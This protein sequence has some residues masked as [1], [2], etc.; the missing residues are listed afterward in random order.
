MPTPIEHLQQRLGLRQTG[1][2][3]GA[4][5]GAILAYQGSAKGQYPMSATGH[6][7]PATLANLG[8]YAPGDIFTSRW[9]AY[10][11]GGS[12]PSTALRDI[13][14]SIDQVPRWVWATAAVSFGV[15]A[16]MAYRTDRKREAGRG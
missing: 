1:T 5:D 4:T 13:Q 12:K 14:T 3:D 8:Y 9:A 10:L 15:F 6:P 11:E 2:W 7:D 16:Y